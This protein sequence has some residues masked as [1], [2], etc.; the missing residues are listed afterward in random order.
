MQHRADTDISGN[1][2]YIV[3]I[4]WLYVALMAAVTEVNLV[5]GVIT[6]LF[7][8]V[9][10]A[11]LV[12]YILGAGRRKRLRKAQEAAED[13]ARAASA[14]DAVHHPVGKGDGAD[15]KTDQ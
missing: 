7:W 6:F 1:H 9:L 3:A 5:A 4:A 12:I 8:G 11:A 2:M 15:A 13:T 14:H 10:P